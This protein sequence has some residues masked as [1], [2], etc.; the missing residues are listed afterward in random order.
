MTYLLAKYALVFLLALI[1][2]FL[3]GHWMTRRSFVDVSESYDDFRDAA[4]RSDTG[5]WNKLWGRLDSFPAPKEVD[6]S[7]VTDRLDGLAYAIENI[8]APRPVDLA[9]VE[10][11]LETVSNAVSAIPAPV[12]ITPIREQVS[13]LERQIRAIPQPQ[14]VDLAPID[15]RLN[16]IEIELGRLGRRLEVVP[17]VKTTPAVAEDAGPVTF[18]TASHGEK[19]NLRRIFGVGPMLEGLLNNH[20]VFYFWQVANWTDNDVDIMDERLDT[21]KGRIVRDNWVEQANQLVSETDSAQ[22]PT[23]TRISA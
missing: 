22:R 15:E 1:S 14:D 6:L 20:G 18:K 23:G 16:A 21:F 9:S 2:G 10:G 7:N 19:D 13:S 11:K 12:D 3:F 4:T 17:Q 8:P 5:Q